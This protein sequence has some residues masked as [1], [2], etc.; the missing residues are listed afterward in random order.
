[1]INNEPLFVLITEGNGVKFVPA[2]CKRTGFIAEDYYEEDKETGKKHAKQR[3][4]ATTECDLIPPANQETIQEE[5]KEEL[6]SKQRDRDRKKR[7]EKEI[8][9]MI[10][11]EEDFR[12]IANGIYETEKESK[13]KSKKKKYVVKLAN[14]NKI[15]SES[16]DSVSGHNKDDSEDEIEELNMNGQI[17]HNKDGK[18]TDPDK[19]SGSLTYPKG[20]GSQY[21]RSVGKNKGANK[22]ECGRRDRKKL[23]KK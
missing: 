19:E 21:Q 23:C 22:E 2:N 7:K 14:R 18:W 3:Q 17:Y 5:D 8:N 9:P 15:D 20:R 4:T 1:M 10:D 16:S 11:V 6:L 13:P 12:S